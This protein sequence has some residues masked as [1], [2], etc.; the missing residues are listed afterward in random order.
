M[1]RANNV[2]CRFLASLAS[3]AVVMVSV[4]SPAQKPTR[5]APDA[6]TEQIEQEARQALEAARARAA[7]IAPAATPDG[8]VSTSPAPGTTPTSVLPA[9]P[10][11]SPAA[12]GASSSA[13]VPA[14]PGGEAAAD[15]A[16][17]AAANGDETV[18]EVEKVVGEDVS[19]REAKRLVQQEA[20][21]KAVRRLAGRF[22]REWTLLGN[23]DSEGQSS[24]YGHAETLL[25]GSGLCVDERVLEEK[26]ESLG[27]N[28]EARYWAK[29]RLRVLGHKGQRDDGFVVQAVLNRNVFQHGDS[30]QLQVTSTRDAYLYILHVQADDKQQTIT[31]FFPGLASPQ[32]VKV[33]AGETFKFPSD[34]QAFPKRGAPLLTA[35][36]QPG[37][38]RNVEQLRV[39]ALKEKAPAI[40]QLAA[41][42]SGSAAQAE[43]L[44]SG[45]V[46]R[47]VAALWQYLA[48]LEPAAWAM[49]T[50][51]YEILRGA[52]KASAPAP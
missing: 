43:R 31:P 38:T 26:R 39:V 33:R 49:R 8:G 42:I 19:P 10:E 36:V 20:C 4:A 48:R 44:T 23:R 12:A 51:V 18:V 50:A 41:A 25:L 35:N 34:D 6:V 46:P 14:K 27:H 52:A 9:T 11:T 3:C 45:Q 40:D 16:A 24:S 32:P 28:G 13:T 15:A 22:V 37:R 1:S 21:G 7:G 2:A 17:A 5:P 47:L 29:V 30:V